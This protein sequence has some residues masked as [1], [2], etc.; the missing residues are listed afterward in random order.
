MSVF[1][2]AWLNCSVCI[3]TTMSDPTRNVIP[4]VVI[5]IIHPN[6]LILVFV[7]I[8]FVSPEVL[9]CYFTSAGGALHSLFLVYESALVVAIAVAS[10]FVL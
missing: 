8:V 1:S 2:F 9:L 4:I 7:F 10:T 3:V 6:V 5:G